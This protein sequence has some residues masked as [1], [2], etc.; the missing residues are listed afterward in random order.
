LNQEKAKLVDTLKGEIF[1]FLG[2]DLRRV[3]KRSLPPND[4]EEEGPQSNQGEGTRHHPAQ[5]RNPDGKGDRVRTVLT[6]PKLKPLPG[7]EDL[8]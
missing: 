2:F 3:R 4:C 6:R 1:G 7:V 8:K 5:R